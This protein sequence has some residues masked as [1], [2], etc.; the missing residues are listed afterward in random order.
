ML[1]REG[2][3]WLAAT[4]DGWRPANAEAVAE[5]DH[6]LGD[7]RLWSEPSYTPPCPDFGANLLLLKV[8]GKPETVRNSLCISQAARV[9]EAA[10]RA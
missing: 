10:L 7:P 5:L 9:V 8:P 4:L 1:I 6:L 3:S 2:S